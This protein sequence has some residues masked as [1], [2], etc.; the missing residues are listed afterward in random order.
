MHSHPKPNLGLSHCLV[1]A[2]VRYDGGDRRDDWIVETLAPH[3]TLW[4]VCPEVEAGFGTPREPMH[5]E[6]GERGVI[7]LLGNDSGRDLTAALRTQVERRVPELAAAG[8][9]GYILKA[10]SPSCGLSVAV[11]GREGAAPGFYAA[12]LVRKLPDLPVVEESGLADA[13]GREAFCIRL[14]ARARLRRFFSSPWTAGGLSAFHAR[15]KMLLL[16]QDRTRYDRL[17]RLVAGAGARPAGALARDYVAGFMA[18]LALAG[19]IGNHV[20]VLQHLAG[21][22]REGL[23]AARRTALHE[24]IEAY[25]NGALPRGRVLALLGDLADELELSW[26]REQSYLAP[27]PPELLAR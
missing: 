25:R 16:A 20:N 15:E 26:V 2:P 8:L 14:F 24:A 17:G 4:P 3:V 23:E 22:F 11:S 21:H 6:A 7:R 27:C 19:S 10:R 13:A 1:G 12:A 5:L 18:A 9:D